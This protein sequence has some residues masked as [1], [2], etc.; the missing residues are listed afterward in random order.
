[1]ENRKKN[2]SRQKKSRRR[3][4]ERGNEKKEVKRCADWLFVVFVFLTA[5]W[6]LLKIVPERRTEHSQG[7]PES[8][9]EYST[10]A[11]ES[12]GGA[13][14]EDIEAAAG[15]LLQENTEATAGVI[16]Q[17]AAEVTAGMASQEVAGATAGMVSQETA[18]A[19]AGMASQENTEATAGAPLQETAEALQDD[20]LW[21]LPKTGIC[22]F[23]EEE[24][25]QLKSEAVEA[26]AQAQ[27]VYADISLSE[28]SPY[29]SNIKDFTDL[30][31]KEAVALL[32]KA[33]YVSVTQDCNMENPEKLEAFYTAY[34]EDREAV[35]TIFDIYQDGFIGAITFLY[36][37]KELQTYYVGIGWQEGGIPEVR[38]T[39]LSDVKE[40]RLTEKGY[41]IYA[42]EQEIVHSNLRQYWRVSPLSDRCRELTKKYISQLSYVRYNML[43]VNWNRENAE[44]ILMPC[45]FDDIYRM[46]TG[47]NY[48]AENGRV[49]AELYE[50]LLTT[51]FPVTVEQV[52]AH[53]GYDENSVSY[54]YEIVTASPYPP[55]GEV[56][57]YR[58]NGDGTITL[59]VDGVW[60]DYDS[61]IAFTNEIVIQPFSDGTFRYLSNSIE[62]KERKAPSSTGKK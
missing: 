1:M 12:E 14:Q 37:E 29:D 22:L 60:P 17:E 3:M 53:C 38:Y 40:I 34:L 50:R 13:I 4:A 45:M 54:P 31:C 49:P 9:I 46:D 25:K 16:S 32:G 28:G 36:R 57:A 20:T 55:F 33:G 23:T 7:A 52:R 24:K 41:F 10:E 11:R 19:T 15:T 48:H 42:Y 44:D 5:G 59:T 18:G 2:R 21:Y 58:E 51:Y 47:E 6:M 62:E 27:E 61:D 8:R 56:V 26:A 35:V 43:V 39:L 30:Q